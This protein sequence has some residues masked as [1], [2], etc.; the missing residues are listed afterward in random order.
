[1]QIE[2]KGR[3]E[4]SI[5]GNIK[6]IEDGLEIKSALGDLQNKGVTG[7][8]VKIIDSFSMT[9]TVIGHLMKL[10]NIDK[11]TISLV[12]GDE[13]LYTLLEELSLIRQFNVRLAGK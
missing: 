9:S 4:L 11:V 10:V 13:R 2:L 6:S 1:M 12:V 7:I 3:N 5:T 8:V